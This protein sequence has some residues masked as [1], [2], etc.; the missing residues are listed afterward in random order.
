MKWWTKLMIPML[1]VGLVGIADAKGKNGGLRG[2]IV[3]IEGNA[4]T[5]SKGKKNGGQNTIIHT[6]A[7]TSI[8]IDGA[9]GKAVTDLQVGER[10][11]VTPYAGTAT[12]I[13]ATTKHKK[14]KNV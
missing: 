13:V 2:K 9:S 5:I 1:V 6:T 4:I 14:K 8:T 10:V 7:T 12:Q 3:S 11:T